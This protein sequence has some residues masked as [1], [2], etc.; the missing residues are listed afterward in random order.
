MGGNEIGARTDN[1]AV[2]KRLPEPETGWP[3]NAL[4]AAQIVLYSRSIATGMMRCS[5]NCVEIIGFPPAGRIEAWA[6]LIIPEDR[7]YF[8][9]AIRSITPQSRQIEEEYRVRHAVT[10]KPFWVLDRG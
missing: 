7:P 4:G 10:G 6:G 2:D 1:G 3:H 5:D 9:N 8:E